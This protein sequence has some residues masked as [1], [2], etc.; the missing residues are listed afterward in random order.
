MAN[1]LPDLVMNADKDGS[2]DMVFHVH[3]SMPNFSS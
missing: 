3:M 1:H 2:S